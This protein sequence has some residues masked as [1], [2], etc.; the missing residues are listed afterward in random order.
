MVDVIEEP[1]DIEQKDACLKAVGMRS[2]D[3]VNEG[4]PRIKAG[5][6]SSPPELDSGDQLVF[7]DIVLERLA[8]AFSINLDIVS[9]NE[10]GRCA[11]AAE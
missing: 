3:V 1:S 7:H 9:S 5:G 2:L 10:M 11:F 6:V 8:T 4:K